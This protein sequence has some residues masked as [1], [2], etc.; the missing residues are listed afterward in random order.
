MR[1]LAIAWLSITQAF[2]CLVIIPAGIVATFLITG[3]LHSGGLTPLTENLMLSQSEV[4]K[5][6]PPGYVMTLNCQTMPA[7][8]GPP[9]VTFTPEEC[10]EQATPIS[11]VA[12][13]ISKAFVLFYTLIVMAVLIAKIL[14]WLIRKK[15]P[16]SV[17]TTICLSNKPST[18]TPPQ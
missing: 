1:F 11:T 3:I 4:F 13:S 16:V 7:P 18:D 10:T 6:A 15:P 9:K 17:R 14:Y 12:Q 8:E 2:V 5:D